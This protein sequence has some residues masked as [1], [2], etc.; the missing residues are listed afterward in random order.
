MN[1]SHR[2][3]VRV[4]VLTVRVNIHVSEVL[5]ICT[6][7]HPANLSACS[8]LKEGLTV[9]RM[10][11]KTQPNHFQQYFFCIAKHFVVGDFEC[12]IWL[13]CNFPH[14]SCLSLYLFSLPM[15]TPEEAHMATSSMRPVLRALRFLYPTW[16]KIKSY[17]SS[18]R[19]PMWVTRTNTI[20]K[21]WILPKC[22]T[23]EI[24]SLFL[25]CCWN[26]DVNGFI[27]RSVEEEAMYR[28]ILLFNVFPHK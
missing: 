20:I 23:I 19:W 16:I 26:V 21:R 2:K 1:E 13:A 14:K 10:A 8:Y 12:S 6:I 18:I 7:L 24:A 25:I 22:F 11:T 3:C 15:P 5:Y 9:C 27:T 17:I 28:I 4:H